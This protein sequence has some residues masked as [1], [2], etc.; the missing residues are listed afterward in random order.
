M[1]AVVIFIFVLLRIVS[2][3]EAQEQSQLAAVGS[4]GFSE[5]YVTPAG[6]VFLFDSKDTVLWYKNPGESIWNR[7]WIPDYHYKKTFDTGYEYSINYCLPLV[8]NKMGLLRGY[9]WPEGEF[10]YCFGPNA[11]KQIQKD[12]PLLF[13]GTDNDSA[14]FKCIHDPEGLC[15]GYQSGLNSEEINRIFLWL[16]S[17]ETV[18]DEKEFYDEIFGLIVNPAAL[19][20][21]EKPCGSEMFKSGARQYHFDASRDA[22]FFIVKDTTFFEDSPSH[23]VIR[24][25]L[26]YSEVPF[27][28]SRILLDTKSNQ[29]FTLSESN[30]IYRFFGPDSFICL[31]KTPLPTN[32]ESICVTNGSVY[33][34]AGSNELYL[35]KINDSVFTREVMLFD[36]GPL[37]P[38]DSIYHCNGK[39]YSILH[40]AVICSEDNGHSWFRES[41]LPLKCIKQKQLNDSVVLIQ[42]GFRPSYSLHTYC[43]AIGDFRPY[44]NDNPLGEFLKFPVERVEIELNMC[45]TYITDE[46]S[47][48]SC[49]Q[50]L[51]YVYDE[52]KKALILQK[53]TTH[54]AEYANFNRQITQEEVTQAIQGIN[55]IPGDSTFDIR[56]LSI[57]SSDIFDYRDLF[58]NRE[59]RHRSHK[60][61]SS[62]YF[63]L[64]WDSLGLIC[65]EAAVQNES[66]FRGIMLNVRM[67][68]SAHEPI[69]LG[70]FYFRNIYSYSWLWPVTYNDFTYSTN[71][72]VFSRFFNS[73]IPVQSIVELQNTKPQLMLNIADFLY[74]QRQ[75]ADENKLH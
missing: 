18:N 14:V 58:R 6:G 57:D 42:S 1:R 5:M 74:R 17:H 72:L 37:V 54:N 63:N 11:M 33:L 64:P 22:F 43:F 31:N 66:P 34:V 10:S 73:I 30:N 4:W 19:F 16:N 41:F 26:V 69:L 49:N 46:L 45:Y 75:I 51:V 12:F 47:H 20:N 39:Q 62:F 27:Q 68:N 40:S 59:I 29:V 38:E 24:D 9:C 28:V 61:D 32:I 48:T 60:C 3:V 52:N 25:S 7:A 55:S 50:H 36:A 53:D 13:Y 8:Q 65:G 44:F 21:Q 15:W 67:I 56:E 71:S 70:T 35:Y 23:L 2:G